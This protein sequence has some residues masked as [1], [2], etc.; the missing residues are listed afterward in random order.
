[1]AIFVYFNILLGFLI[2]LYKDY[3]PSIPAHLLSTPPPPSGLVTTPLQSGTALLMVDI[4]NFLSE[5]ILHKEN[6]QISANIYLDYVTSKVNS[7]NIITLKDSYYDLSNLKPIIG[8]K[9]ND[10]VTFVHTHHIIMVSPIIK[11]V[12]FCLQN[13]YIMVP[14]II[15]ALKPLLDTFP[16][17]LVI[18]LEKLLNLSKI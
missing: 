16:D 3:C 6:M 9:L 17:K 11:Y 5:Q 2:K 7:T 10:I 8:F 14:A 4:L 13:I 18:L 1:M 15:F 12:N